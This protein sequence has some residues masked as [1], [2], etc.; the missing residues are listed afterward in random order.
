MV[1]R[2]I[3]VLACTLLLTLV[4]AAGQANADRVHFRN[5]GGRWSRSRHAGW[6]RYW[7]GPTNGYYWAPAPVYV[8]PGYR[9]ARY[10]SG[11]D[12]WYSNPSFGLSINIGGGSSRRVWHDERDNRR[13]IYRERDRDD[14]G[15][16]RNHGDHHDNGV[17]D[18]GRGHGRDK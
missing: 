8:V 2:Q 7:G 15:R 4:F 1:R 3:T 13:V 18:H 9:E 5:N 14:W 17:R 11:P 16:G 10:Y 12:F 6:H